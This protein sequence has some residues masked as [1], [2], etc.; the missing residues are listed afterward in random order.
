MP[1]GE[2][3]RHI[4]RW[5]ERERASDLAWIQENLPQLWSA[6][7]LGFEMLGRGAVTVD[8]TVQ[9]VPDKG[10]PMWYLTQ[11]QVN[12]YTGED[13]IRMVAEYDPT[14]EFVNILL[15]QNERVSSYRVGVP[16]QRQ[17]PNKG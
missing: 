13:E 15:K 5:A 11:E 16:G 14:W 3:K 2:R 1:E 12:N 10:H 9:P 6:A 4:P 7:L 8:T 17:Q